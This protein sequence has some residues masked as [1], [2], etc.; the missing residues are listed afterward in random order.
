MIARNIT[1][2]VLAALDSNTDQR[3]AFEETL[4]TVFGPAGAR[5][6]AMLPGSLTLD[7]MRIGTLCYVS[8]ALRAGQP[9]VTARP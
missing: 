9:A 7:G 1:P 3:V 2:N 4:E 5:E 8:M 6:W